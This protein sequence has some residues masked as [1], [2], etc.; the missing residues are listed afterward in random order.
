M[1]WMVNQTFGEVKLKRK[2]Q[3]TF[4]ASINGT[5]KYEIMVIEKPSSIVLTNNMYSEISQLNMK[6]I[7]SLN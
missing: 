1:S 2:R 5:K 7:C 6:I 4:L 3:V